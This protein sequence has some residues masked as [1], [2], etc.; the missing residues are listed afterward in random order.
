[1]TIQFSGQTWHMQPISFVQAQWCLSRASSQTLSVQILSLLARMD[2]V[3]NVLG[4]YP[5][6]SL[7]SD[8]LQCWYILSSGLTLIRTLKA[9]CPNCLE[10]SGMYN[11]VESCPSDFFRFLVI[12]FSF[13]IAVPLLILIH[14]SSLAMSSPCYLL[15]IQ[16]GLSNLDAS[17][18]SSILG[19]TIALVGS[20]PTSMIFWLWSIL[21]FSRRLLTSSLKAQCDQTSTIPRAG[22]SWIMVSCLLDHPVVTRALPSVIT[23]KGASVLAD[24][25]TCFAT[26]VTAVVISSFAAGVSD[27]MFPFSYEWCAA[28]SI[29]IDF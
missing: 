18:L 15:F 10:I 29:A 20:A 13:A 5:V 26:K 25:D 6:T 7:Q 19:M 28:K 9:F 16:V 3:R 2:T 1:M 24:I 22:Q 17:F 4:G 21:I 27:N 12:N 23:I 11:L 14:G 8:V